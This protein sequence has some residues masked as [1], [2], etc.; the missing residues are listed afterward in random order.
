MMTAC[1]T[2]MTMLI[3]LAIWS[4]SALSLM[5]PVKLVHLDKMVVVSEKVFIITT[6]RYLSWFII[7]LDSTTTC[8]LTTE[9][10]LFRQCSSEYVTTN[11][12]TTTI[13]PNGCNVDFLRVD[14]SCY[15]SSPGFP[16]GYDDYACKDWSLRPDIE[17]QSL[18]IEFDTFEVSV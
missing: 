1:T 8:E 4:M 7:G 6:H 5:K 10:T 16:S 9:A 3:P 13:G 12:Q 11:P 17:T 14:D 15:I 18:T 2:L